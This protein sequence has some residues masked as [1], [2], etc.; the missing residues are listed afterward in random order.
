MANTVSVTARLAVSNSNTQGSAV[1]GRSFAPTVAGGRK[2]CNTQSVQNTPE[3]LVVNDMGSLRYLSLVNPS[4]SGKTLT[5][6]CA[7]IVMQPGDSAIFPPA[8]TAVTL[9]ATASSIDVEVVG[10]EA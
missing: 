8:S 10:T 7:A 4:D 3:A 5:V 9:Q 1:G 2:L 6:T